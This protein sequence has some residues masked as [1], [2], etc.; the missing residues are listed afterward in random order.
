MDSLLVAILLALSV[1]ADA[2][3]C[4]FGAG[5]SRIKVPVRSAVTAAAVS[6][7][8]VAAGMA[9]GHYSAP[10]MPDAVQKYISFA[11]LAA[12]GLLKLASG[13]EG[14]SAF[15]D[16]NTD[17]VLSAAEGAAL[18]AALSI[19]GLAAGFGY[20]ANGWTLAFSSAFTF[21]FTAFALFLGAKG[22]RGVRRG[23]AGNVAAG[24]VLVLL[25]AEKLLGS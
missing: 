7:A 11:V 10:F 21:L 17:R 12:F 19:D 3:A 1:S 25:A 2:L 23:R 20:A 5:A 18:G 13:G 16:C 9:A 22:G 8:F 4:G 6:A 24:L 15:A 14:N